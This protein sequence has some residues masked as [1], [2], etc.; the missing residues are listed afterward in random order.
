MNLIIS[1]QTHIIDRTQQPSPED[2]MSEASRF[3]ARQKH[4][5]S[6]PTFHHKV[7]PASIVQEENDLRCTAVQ[8][9]NHY[10]QYMANN[11]C[12]TLSVH[13]NSLTIAPLIHN[14]NTETETAPHGNDRNILFIHRSPLPGNSQVCSVDRQ[15]RKFTQRLLDQ[16]MKGS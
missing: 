5:S 6:D 13:G 12:R 1:K 14:F 2:K 16:K 3:R 9:I 7:L 4:S 8:E 15:W 10:K 11:Q